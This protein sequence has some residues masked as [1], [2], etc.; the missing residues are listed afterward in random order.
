MMVVDKLSIF[1]FQ[2]T[3]VK[4]SLEY[5]DVQLR[6]SMNFEIIC[7]SKL[8]LE[9]E[10]NKGKAPGSLLFHVQLWTEPFSERSLN[11]V[12]EEQEMVPTKALGSF[13][14]KP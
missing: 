3:H 13:S 5:E 2:E 10:I 11:E 7:G 6:A 14:M 4:H 12:T 8:K 1:S 9:I